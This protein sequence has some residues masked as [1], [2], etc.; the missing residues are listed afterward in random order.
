MNIIRLEEWTDRNI[1]RLIL[2]RENPGTDTIQC[3]LTGREL[4][5]Y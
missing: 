5:V 1:V 3:R 4:T 2:K